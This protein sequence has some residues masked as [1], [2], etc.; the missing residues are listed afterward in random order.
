V[1]R[2]AGPDG[3]LDAHIRGDLSLTTSMREIGD[4]PLGR[5]PRVAI[6]SHVMF[7]ARDIQLKAGQPRSWD[8][9]LTASTPIARTIK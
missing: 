1:I 2:L 8:I 9:T 6:P 4:E 7:E 5:G 3:N